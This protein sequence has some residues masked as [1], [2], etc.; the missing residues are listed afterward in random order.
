[1]YDLVDDYSILRIAREARKFEKARLVRIRAG[2]I[3]NNL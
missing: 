1:M 2:I 3:E